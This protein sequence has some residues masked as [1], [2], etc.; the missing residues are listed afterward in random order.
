MA[1]Q[2]SGAETRGV[3]S[4]VDALMPRHVTEVPGLLLG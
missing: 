4:L 2:R 3:D 1:D